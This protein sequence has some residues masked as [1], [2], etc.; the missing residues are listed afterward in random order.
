MGIGFRS[1]LLRTSSILIWVPFLPLPFR[2]QISLLSRLLFLSVQP[3]LPASLLC[4][5]SHL[6]S[7]LL[8]PFLCPYS[9]PWASGN[10]LQNAL[11]TIICPG[12]S[13]RRNVPLA[14]G[15]KGFY[16]NDKRRYDPS[17]VHNYIH[18]RADIVT[19]RGVYIYIYIYGL[20]LLT[21]PCENAHL[22][23]VYMY[24]SLSLYIYIYVG[25]RWSGFLGSSERLIKEVN[26]SIRL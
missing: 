24:L 8:L 1:A 22:Y 10:L 12:Y 11:E 25:I 17:D 7:N 2:T 26:I 3:F 4:N 13:K 14:E 16:E 5:S 19:K 6:S 20:G 18:G 9:S 21:A 23:N 15:E